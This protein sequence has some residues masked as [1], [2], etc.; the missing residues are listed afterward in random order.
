VICLCL[1]NGRL[2]F[3]CNLLAIKTED[4]QPTTSTSISPSHIATQTYRS[5]TTLTILHRHPL[6]TGSEVAVFQPAIS[7]QCKPVTIQL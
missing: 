7:A 2:P 3:Q 4:I 6:P 1:S 5:D